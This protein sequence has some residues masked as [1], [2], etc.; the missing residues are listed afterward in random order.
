MPT[1]TSVAL[2]FSISS[3]RQPTGGPVTSRN[4]DD[5]PTEQIAGVHLGDQ[6]FLISFVLVAAWMVASLE[7]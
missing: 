7:G 2:S 4:A 3:I 1:A 5:D 6:R